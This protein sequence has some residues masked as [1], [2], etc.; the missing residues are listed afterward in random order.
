MTRLVSGKVVK[1]PSANVSADR[2]QFL[3][4]A[5]A[6]PDLGLPPSNN[7]ALSSDPQ[8][9]RK[10]ID[11][12]T[13]LGNSDVAIGNVFA[14][15]TLYGNNLIVRNIDILDA[16]IGETT[17]ANVIIAKQIFAANVTTDR[18]TANIWE[19]IY[20]ANVI[21]SPENLF[22]SNDRVIANLNL[23]SIDIFGDVADLSN[24]DFG[25]GLLWDGN[26]FA[27]V[28]ISSELANIADLALRVTSLEN[29][30]TAN[31]AEASSNLYFTNTRAIAALVGANVV[32]NNLFVAGDLTVQGNSAILNVSTL[33][34]EDK[35]IVVANGAVSAAT[36]DGAGI[37]IQG[38]DANI[39]YR[40]SGDKFEINKNLDVTGNIIA[41]SGTGGSI[42]GANLITAETFTANLLR[43][44]TIVS[45]TLVNFNTLTTRTIF[46]NIVAN[47]IRTD[48]ITTISLQSN[49]LVSNLLSITGVAQVN[50]YDVLTK[51]LTD[52]TFEPM[53]H[54]NKAN[55]QISFNANT[56]TF[57]IQPTDN[58]Y[59][60]WVK[61]N[62][63]VKNG[64]ESVVIANTSGLYYIYFNTNGN[65]AVRSS[66][67]D[68][69]N[70]AP[71]A[72]IYFN[73]NTQAA[74]F[75]ADE[76]HGITLD[77][78]THEYLH[79]TRG[80]AIAEGFSISNYTDSGN[81]SLDSHA[82]LDISNGTFFDED[83]EVHI[84]HS[85]TPTPNT[86]EQD[87]QGPARIPM[88]YL[89]G[90]EWIRDEP[91]DFPL[92]QGT[93]RI[94]Y[95]QLSGGQWTTPDVPTNT[96]Y[97]TSWIIAT[98]NVNYPIIAIM[99]QSHHNNIGN[100]E[101]INFQDLTLTNFPVIEF[102]PLYKIIWQTNANYGNTPK[103]VI[104]E[105]YDLRNVISASP[106]AAIASDHGLL[107]GLGDD[108]HSQ[109][110]HIE[111]A[112]TVTAGHTFSA[113][114][115]FAN[116]IVSELLAGNLTGQV[117]DISNH[118]INA[119]YD[120]DITN[121]TINS[122][123][124]WN[125][126][127]F[128]TG[129]ADTALFSESANLASRANLV[130][131]LDNFTT[132]NLIE[133]GDNQY[134]TN[135]R[136]RQAFTAGTGIVIQENGNIQVSDN[137]LTG[138]VTAST[139][140]SNTLTLDILRSN[141]VYTKDV[142]ANG[143]VIANGLII[144]NIEV[145][146][147]ILTG[148]ITA[149]TITSNTLVLDIITANVFNGLPAANLDLLT[150]DDLNEGSSNL[151]FTIPRARTA[152]SGGLGIAI[153]AN[154][155]ISAKGDDTGTGMFNSGINLLAGG[156]T[157]DVYANTTVFSAADGASFILYSFHITNLTS[158]TAYLKGRYVA[159]GIPVLFADM[160]EI[161]ADSSQELLRKPHVFKP[162]DYIQLQSFNS[163]GNAAP[164]V[165]STYISYQASTDELYNR[166]ANTLTNNDAVFVF[167]SP[168][169]ASII[170][171]YTLVNLSQ[172][173]VPVTTMLT[174]AAGNTTNYITSNLRIPP[175][176]SIEVCEYPKAVPEDYKIRVNKFGNP[177][178]Q[179]SLFITSKF[180]SF[181]SI[182]PS[183][184]NMT[185]G[186]S[187]I[188]NIE[189]LNL[190]GGT[191]LY[192]T[193]ESMAGNVSQADFDTPIQGSVTV[194]NDSASLTI[195]ANTDNNTSF[196]GN[197]IFRVQLRKGSTS[198][199][200]VATSANVSI[201]DTSNLVTFTVL[202][203][204]A[205]LYYDATDPGV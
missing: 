101:S 70:D 143:N 40:E 175:G 44:D 202:E 125:G 8:G 81:G 169:R 200:V 195:T 90:T 194:N 182:A 47:V 71:T 186:Q 197:E 203:S 171:A 123:L 83:L 147:N 87:L 127:K 119:L 13:T 95:N 48:T 28:Y 78:A 100:Q 3:E 113:T 176:S 27:P 149:S 51:E 179:V 107:S 158:E 46:A 4:L 35:N 73:A 11:L 191:V 26:A 84:T 1:V 144:R 20:T 188:F 77:W 122:T 18:I 65:V 177:A 56:R 39:T 106:S 97:T 137:I 157:E 67:F 136:A 2:Y 201:L 198:G 82:Q 54:E 184:G 156:Y 155:V 178:D 80:A 105:V 185:E 75:F 61:G 124:I 109:Y 196:E 53:G 173:T 103:A 140:T 79:R 36:A 162:G 161:E 199:I 163:T 91:T 38:A 181:Y 193:I 12:T 33:V 23:A 41:G 22:Y 128:V 114:Q 174:N 141:L 167:D 14:A 19:G 102:R 68:W 112:R 168:G 32:L 126:S 164:N 34:V 183:S 166:V 192:Y 115:S 10:W 16:L 94:K 135:T 6:E 205:A 138:N 85:N 187:V 98:N 49:S 30:T 45:N 190:A 74:P 180:T 120:V 92:K 17:L 59:T 52:A 15:G 55:S 104:R 110:L 139:I 50:G 57:T 25:Q 76:R 86:W 31:V 111:N 9:N 21:E 60:V 96:H 150:T 63:F 142:I 133:G 66:Y 134:F 129:A 116:V 29:F 117:S 131:S 7:Y 89:V 159:N 165:L 148:N 189:T 145:S 62:K 24:I 93:A 37:S 152:F 151:Y 118:S 5:E 42:T 154:G 58:S 170:E 204:S 69:E 99:G 72:Y 132:A 130:L 172:N 160:L 108:D 121:V 64:T 153:S 88:F 146:D 43:T